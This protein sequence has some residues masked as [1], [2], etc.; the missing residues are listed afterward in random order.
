M[1][2]LDTKLMMTGSVKQLGE[3]DG[4]FEKKFMMMHFSS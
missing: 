2:F 4:F 1:K 3:F